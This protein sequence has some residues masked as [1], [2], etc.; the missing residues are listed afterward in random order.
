V[1]FS[2]LLTDRSLSAVAS[3]AR[4]R[5]SLSRFAYLRFLVRASK[6]SGQKRASIFLP[7]GADNREFFG[8]ASLKIKRP[9]GRCIFCGRGDLSKEHI[10][11]DWLQSIIPM[12]THRFESHFNIRDA[13]GNLIPDQI[14]KPKQG[15]IHT[16][17]ARCVCRKCNNEWMGHIV[18]SAKPCAKKLV[19]GE[20]IVLSPDDQSRVASWLCLWAMAANRIAKTPHKFPASDLTH[21]YVHRTTPQHWRIHIGY[22]NEPSQPMRIDFD[23]SPFTLFQE[24][25]K[26][27]K[28]ASRFVVH[29]MTTVVGHLYAT[30]YCPDPL[31]DPLAQIVPD[32]IHLPYLLPIWPTIGD[33][34]FPSSVPVTG[35]LT[36][37]G[38]VA[39][40][41]AT[42]LTM[43]MV[44]ICNAA[45]IPTR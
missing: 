18:E 5:F 36:M 27:R 4:S 44:R 22:Y 25:N 10:W 7:H 6:A 38:G 39:R 26:T 16:K 20:K 15:A 1:A 30:L 9:P 8:M 43:F 17:K 13:L 19:K 41:L 35:M 34:I 11:S 29:S 24:E 28:L 3:H 33:L 31:S 14:L 40:D 45:G 37:N 32:G 23:N 12:T 21:M 42:R 2:T